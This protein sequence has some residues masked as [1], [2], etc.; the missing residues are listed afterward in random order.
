MLN[1]FYSGRN[2][3]IFSL[4]E[5]VAFLSDAKFKM[6][7]A[8]VGGAKIFGFGPNRMNRGFKAIKNNKYPW[9]VEH[10]E[11]A[12]IRDTLVKCGVKMNGDIPL[13]E[14]LRILRGTTIYVF[15]QWRNGHPAMARPCLCCQ[16]GLLKP[17]GFKKMVYSIPEDPYFR[18]EIL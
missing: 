10:C 12:A 2:S 1:G 16:K 9:S 11:L 8:I 7:A 3:E 17:L 6:A 15:R 18:E 13:G 14:A 4:L 5:R